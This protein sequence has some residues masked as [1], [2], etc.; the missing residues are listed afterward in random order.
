MSPTQSDIYIKTH[1]SESQGQRGS[2][3]RR[4]HMSILQ[5][6]T[7]LK[8]QMALL[9]SLKRLRFNTPDNKSP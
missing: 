2:T 4:T 7:L 9:T 1:G 3:S 6:Q 5:E 8:Y